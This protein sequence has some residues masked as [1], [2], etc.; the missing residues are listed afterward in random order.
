MLKKNQAEFTSTQKLLL[1]FVIIKI[2]LQFCF[3]M[4]KYVYIQLFNFF[5]GVLYFENVFN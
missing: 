1:Q 2:L 5:Y 3:H 4:W